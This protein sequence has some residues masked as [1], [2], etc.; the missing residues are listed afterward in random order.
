MTV[1]A[2]EAGSAGL[3]GIGKLLTPKGPAAPASGEFSFGIVTP[4]LGLGPGLCA[5]A[6]A[7]ARRE[8]RLE[9]MER[10]LRTPELL[11]AVQ[12]DAILCVAPP[13]EAKDG[14]IAGIVALVVRQGQSVLLETGAWH[15]IPFPLSPGGARF[16]VIFKNGTGEEDLEIRELRDA[17]DIEWKGATP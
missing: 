4:E 9:K 8:A 6:L 7:C 16:M 13:Q 5:G 10:H 14:A 2:I 12:G 17:R 1:R 11:S 15:W 3:E